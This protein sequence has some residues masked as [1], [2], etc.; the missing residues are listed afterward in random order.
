[1]LHTV[2]DE[3]LQDKYPTTATGRKPVKARIAVDPKEFRAKLQKKIEELRQLEISESVI[4]N[5]LLQTREI[6]GSESSVPFGMGRQRF[7]S[8]AAEEEHNTLFMTYL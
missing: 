7:N 6:A 4:F 1:M 3:F 8:A 2:T 5:E